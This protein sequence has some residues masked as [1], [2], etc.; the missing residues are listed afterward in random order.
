MNMDIKDLKIVSE[1]QLKKVKEDYGSLLRAIEYFK[2]NPE[3]KRVDILR[4]LKDSIEF[5]ATLDSL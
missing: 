4:I 3:T 2:D 5:R 1:K